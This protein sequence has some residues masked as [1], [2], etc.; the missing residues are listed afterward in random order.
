MK[1]FNE[2]LV[3]IYTHQ[4]QTANLY[5]EKNTISKIIERDQMVKCRDDGNDVYVD[6]D[7]IALF[8]ILEDRKQETTNVPSEPQQDNSSASIETLPEL[9]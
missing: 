6:L 9:R 3:K 5:A 7:C 1:N 4:G 2:K 8:E